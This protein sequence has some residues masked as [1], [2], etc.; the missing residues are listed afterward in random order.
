MK[1]LILKV[2]LCFAC[3]FTSV[4]TVF[5]CGPTPQKVVKEITIKADPATIWQVIKQ[6][7]AIAQWHPD[8]QTSVS[9]QK[10]DDEGES[11][12]YRLV[13]L[14]N[15]LKLEEKRRDTTDVDMKLDYQM[16]QGD[17]PVSNYRG[18]MQIKPSEVAGE[19]IV[20]WTGRFNNKANTLDAPAGQD[21]ATA[22][23][24]IELFY[25]DGLAG[26]K[27]MIEGSSKK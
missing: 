11:A 10:L 9:L 25:D 16:S 27:T 18:V 13:T 24:A 7:D 2:V 26:L 14:K 1:K 22:I 5:A 8:V 6:F 21:N 15:G 12:S 17:F 19:T 4:M 23:H 3:M 20:S